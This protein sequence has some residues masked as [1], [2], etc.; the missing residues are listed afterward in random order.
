[1]NHAGIFLRILAVTAL[2]TAGLGPVHAQAG[3]APAVLPVPE[4]I[5]AH[6]EIAYVENGHARQ[7]LDLYLP[8]KSGEKLP[9]IGWIQ[10]GA[11]S[12]GDKNGCPPLRQGY[13]QRGYA[14]A[15]L[16]YRLSQH[17]TFPA[18]LE[19]CKAALRWLRAQARRCRTACR[20]HRSRD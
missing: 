1:M 10:G 5:T 13:V 18:Q 8:E 20:I 14:V 11:W 3:K 7:V 9:V 15:S 4:G 19:D 2:L 12:A 16:N 17:A 6:R